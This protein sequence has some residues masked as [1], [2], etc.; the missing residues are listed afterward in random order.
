M[1]KR[2]LGICR[3]FTASVYVLLSDLVVWLQLDVGL[4][5]KLLDW[6][7]EG[8]IP[9]T[10][11][12]SAVQASQFQ[13]QTVYT[14]Q[15]EPQPNC[16]ECT[17]SENNSQEPTIEDQLRNQLQRAAAALEI[18]LRRINE[19]SAVIDKQEAELRRCDQLL[20]KLKQRGTMLETP[21]GTRVDVKDLEHNLL[22]HEWSVSEDRDRRHEQLDFVRSVH[23]QLSDLK[24]GP[25]T[26][27]YDQSLSLTE[28]I[29]R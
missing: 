11:S 26:P 2:S 29:D 24:V 18:A 19:D 28:A 10:Y 3:C 25:G 7:R 9:E 4:K 8:H 27:D 5:C 13:L 12:K 17:P 1:P 15:P 14:P 22:R 23:D 20:E 16:Q 21:R 6:A